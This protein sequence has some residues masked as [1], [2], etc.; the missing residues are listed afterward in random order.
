VQAGIRALA[1]RGHGVTNIAPALATALEHFR[2][3]PPT[4]ARVILL[5]SDGAARMEEEARDALRQLFQD[6]GA[7]LYWIYLRNPRSGRLSAPPDNPNESTSP[8]VFLH[9]YFQTLGVPY[10]A[11]ETEN[12]QAL[13]DAIR[14]VEQLENQPLRYRERVPRQDW[15]G[16]CYGLALASLVILLVFQTFEIRAWPE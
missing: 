7:S 3:R 14:D 8:E 11:Y 9:Q 4:G 10:Q 5:V 1:G 12:P 16:A 2:G 13:R 15:S 6:T